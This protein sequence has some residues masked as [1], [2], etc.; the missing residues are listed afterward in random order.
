[1]VT[2]YFISAD[3]RD[4][5]NEEWRKIPGY[6]RYRITQ[7]GDIRNV[8]TGRL[9][10]E[11]EDKKTGAWSYTLYADNGKTTHRKWEGLVELAFPE[12]DP[13]WKDVEGWPGYQM[14]H[15]GKIRG[16]RLKNIL[17]VTGANTVT[18]RKDKKRYTVAIETL[19]PLKEEEAA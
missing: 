15:E 12:L 11:T 5:R 4:L 9:L 3:G 14:N 1:M 7:V 18:M 2:R 16:T 13:E 8:R 10:A 6:S 17:P 19:T